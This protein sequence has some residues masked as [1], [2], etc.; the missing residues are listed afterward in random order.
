VMAGN[1]DALRFYARRGLVPGEV[2]L[3]R[4]R[5]ARADPGT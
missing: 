2:L 1:T 4:F 5:A 3:Y